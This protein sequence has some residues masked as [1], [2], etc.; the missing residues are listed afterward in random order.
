MN[1]EE[2][3]DPTGMYMTERLDGMRIMWTGSEMLTKNGNSI[4]FPASF[5]EGWPTTYLDGQLW[6]DREKYA[7]LV[8][9]VRKRQPDHKAWLEIKFIVFDAPLLQEVYS[10][11]YSK[12]K[13]VILSIK[14]PH[15]VYIPNIMC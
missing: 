8:S 14:N 4:N 2:N 5:I 11:R 3:Q 1:W 13:K 7:K 6:I 9:I 12:L 15:L 10:E